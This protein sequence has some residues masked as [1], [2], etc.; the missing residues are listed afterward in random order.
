MQRGW[1]V[2]GAFDEVADVVPLEGLALSDSDDVRWF[3]AVAVK[4]NG[5]KVWGDIDRAFAE[6]DT[7]MLKL[8]VDVTSSS[9]LNLLSTFD[10]NGKTLTVAGG[11]VAFKAASRVEAAS[12]GQI[13]TSGGSVSAE[14]GSTFTFEP[15]AAW[16]ASG[17]TVEENAGVWTVVYDH[18]CDWGMSVAGDTLTAVCSGAGTCKYGN[19]LILALSAA[20]AVYDG[21]PKGAALDVSAA[22]TFVAAT[23]AEIGEVNYTG[24]TS[25]GASY[26]SAEAPT[27]TGSY[28]AKVVVTDMKHALAQYTITKD[29]AITPRPLTGV[30]ETTYVMTVPLD[31]IR[32]YDKY[33]NLV[34]AYAGIVISALIVKSGVGV[35]KGTVAELL[36][37]PGEAELAERLYRRIRETEGVESAADMMLHNYGPDAWSGSVNVEMDH[38]LSVGEAY[39]VLHALQLAIM[40]EEKVTMVFGVY[41]VDRDH[42]DSKV[43]RTAVVD[44]VR[45]REHVKSFHA[46]YL[47]PG[48]GRIYCDLVVDYALRD[49]EP[50]REEFVGYMKNAFPENEVVLTIETEFV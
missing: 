24:F 13:I 33:G 47:E 35:L 34:D 49:W 22:A 21:T 39:G 4:D 11:T 14:L 20:D 8:E 17:L 40:R 7:G 45:R 31:S 12:A 5:E 2:R 28:R 36:G 25:A 32:F 15:N 46:I 6:F 23:G 18:V 3:P 30:R 37:R 26:D 48:T 27:D 29:Y 44:F 42:E 19:Q 41:A 10:L 50:L 43:V 16:L 38:D 1:V 9:D